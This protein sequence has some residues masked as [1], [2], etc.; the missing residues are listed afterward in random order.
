MIPTTSVTAGNPAATQP[1]YGAEPA[2]TLCR[3]PA[4]ADGALG[5][6]IAV[7]SQRLPEAPPLIAVHGIKRSAMAMASG[8]AAAAAARG[9]VVVAPEFTKEA[10]PQYQQVVRQGRA[11]K[12]LLSLLAACRAAGFWHGGRLDLVG[13]SGGAQ[14]AHRF[15]MLYPHLVGRLTLVA[16]GWY[17]FPDGAAFPYGL[18][19]RS[20]AAGRSAGFSAEFRAG[21]RTGHSAGCSE[22]G[23]RM[24]EGLEAYLARPI[25]IVVGQS[26]T[27][28]DEYLRR[29]G[30]L[31]AQQGCSRLQRA[32]TYAAALR[33][34]ADARGIIPDI[35]CAVLPGA[36]HDLQQC[37]GGHRL[38]R[39]ALGV[40]TRLPCGVTNQA[41]PTHAPFTTTSK[42]EVTP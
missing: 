31:D 15:A 27:Q 32:I 25:R 10:W 12:A 23:A 33:R 39:L 21:F 29:G 6:W 4:G 38:A 35:A 22:W 40:A 28:S 8:F 37:L 2:Y 26:D 30:D 36:G 13:Y 34:A 17:T 41:I 20:D 11:D 18:A 24:A 16:A 42:T 5:A 1:C 7:P 3:W 19:T 9:R 14:F